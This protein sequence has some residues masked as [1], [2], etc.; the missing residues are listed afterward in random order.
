MIK[1]KKIRAVLYI[2][3]L[4]LI[5]SVFSTFTVTK[6]VAAENT[7]YYA[8]LDDYDDVLT[9]EEETEVLDVLSKAADKSGYNIGVVITNDLKGM[10]DR[11]YTENYLDMNFGRTSDSI[12]LMILNTHNNPSYDK[13]VDWISVSG[14][15]EKKLGGKSTNIFNSFY[16]SLGKNGY[17][18]ALGTFANNVVK[19][20]GNGS[21]V[22]TVQDGEYAASLDDFDDC[23]TDSE[24]ADV[25]ESLREAAE[26]A[27]C[28]VGIVITHDLEGRSDEKYA[29]NYLDSTFGTGS[30]SVV[31]MLLNTY[32]NEAYS[33][34][35]DCISTSGEG[36]DKYDNKIDNMLDMVYD[37]L[38]KSDGSLDFYNGCLAFCAAMTRYGNGG[39]SYSVKYAAS[40]T[41]GFFSVNFGRILFAVI[42][43]I[44]ITSIVV[45]TSVSGYKKKKTLS[46]SAYLDTRQTR[47]TNSVDRFIR[48][49]TTSVH[50]SSSSSGGHGGGHHGG[51]GG[52]HHSGGHGGGHGHH[53]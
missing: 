19:Y 48:E 49:Y 12:V 2:V 52:G 11:E 9:D 37:E 43:A 26:S 40:D 8:L 7:Y 46:A 13:Y 53:R 5:I 21:A 17:A 3:V 34:Y 20:S 41:I 51:G 18:L 33:S 15:A 14:K 10:T 6:A 35:T 32:G 31:L 29:E 23:L 44:V 50:L 36:M 42:V 30:S 28:N 16:D 38:E 27:K 45:G 24:E 1:A 25:L 47:I 39:G 4:A 22:T